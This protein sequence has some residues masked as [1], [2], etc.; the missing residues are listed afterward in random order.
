[1]ADGDEALCK[2]EYLDTPD[3][4]PEETNWIKRAGR[5]KVTYPNGAIFEGTFDAERVKQGKGVYTWMKASGDD[6]SLMC[7]MIIILLVLI[8][9]IYSAAGRGKSSARAV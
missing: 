3:G 1:M 4:V 2:V 9:T 5:C 6:V 8:Y 7:T